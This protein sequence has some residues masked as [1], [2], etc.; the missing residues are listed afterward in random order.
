MK[1]ICKRLFMLCAFLGVFTILP[2]T[3][4]AA[5]LSMKNTDFQITLKY[6]DR[7][8]F[9][10]E[11]KEIKTISVKSDNVQTG[12]KD[13]E[14]LKIQEGSDNKVVAAG[15]GKAVVELKS[16][17]KIGVTVKAAKI[18]LLLL[19]GQSNMEGSPDKLGSL[20]EYQ[21]EY[22]VNK[23]G[24]VYSTYGP[25]TLSH[26]LTNGCFQTVSPKLT[27]WNPDEYVP[28]SLTDNSSEKEWKRTNNLTDA[29]QATGKTGVDGALAKEWVKRTDE[30]VWLVNAAHSGSSIDTWLP[31]KERINNNFWQA[32]SLYKT[33]EQLLNKE[34]EAGH[35]KLSHKGYFWLQGETD[36]NMS[37]KKYLEKF[38]K[39]HNGIK[40]E[41]GTGRVKKYKNVDQKIEFAGI[42]M[43][44]AH[45]DPT[46]NSDL[47]MTGPR[48]AQYYMCN[49]SKEKFKDIYL[50]SHISEDWVTDAGVDLYFKSKY[51][52]IEKYMEFNNM[53][54]QDVEIPSQVEDV[55]QSVHYTQLGYNELGRDAAANI[56]YALK[57]VKAPESETQIRLVGTDGYTDITSAVKAKEDDMS[58]TVKIFPAYK[59]KSLEVMRKEGISLN[60]WNVKLQ[61]DN[62]FSGQVKYM[63]GGKSRIYTLWSENG[64]SSIQ[65]VMKVPGGI[66]IDWK[67]LDKASYYKVFR[68]VVGTNKWV[69]IKKTK[70]NNNISYTDYEAEQGTDYEYMVRAFDKYGT[71]GK[72]SISYIAA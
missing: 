68:R 43:V 8:T 12:G 4:E 14:V 49:S 28:G 39:M 63:A 20:E 70:K 17:K 47:Y 11:I 26:S 44:R 32:V 64:A 13:S 54:K 51:P 61:S 35:Y 52:T 30:K 2:E 6:D 5:K 42:L 33:C 65:N 24:K 66:K 16:G 31:G 55:H 41:L 7:Y 38:L 57:Y 72:N 21:N 53:K 19:I 67:K 10:K 48:K 58:V 29:E 36:D 15:C 22:V 9:K 25:S 59:A 71:K 37:A 46:D 56:C 60:R 45:G 23:E 62:Y 69:C 40:N 3:A 18:S 27:I 34:I 50:A 1:N